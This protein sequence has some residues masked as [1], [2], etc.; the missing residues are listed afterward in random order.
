[1]LIELDSDAHL[2]MDECV[3]KNNAPICLFDMGGT[4]RATCSFYIKNSTITDNESLVMGEDIYI[5]G[6]FENCT[7]NKNENPQ[8]SAEDFSPVSDLTL[9]NCSMGDSSYDD[10][11]LKNIFFQDADGNA[12]ATGS[13]FGE[14]SPAMIVALLGLI[15]AVAS[16]CVSAAMNKKKNS[17][18]PVA[19]KDKE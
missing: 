10:Y 2:E 8:R 5:S 3:I 7:F 17:P 13:I 16:I 12:I 18:A 6:C 19:A 15:T 4:G 11:R 1:M 14:G 9:R